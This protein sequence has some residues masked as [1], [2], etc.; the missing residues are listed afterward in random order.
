M[1]DFLARLRDELLAAENAR[2]RAQQVEAGASQTNGCRAELVMLGNG[3]PES[4]PR[5][6]W[7]AWVGNA[8]HERFAAQ[9]V[10]PGR[11]L[12]QRFSYR[13]VPCTIDRHD[14]DDESC[15]DWKSKGNAADIAV[16]RKD[17][18]K[19][20][21]IAQVHLGAAA[22]IEAGLP[23]RNVR[24]VYVPRDGDLSDAYV[25]EA[26]FD[27]SLADEAAEWHEKV[28]ALTFE[29][30]GLPVE[31]MVDGLRDEPPSFCWTYCSRVTACRGPRPDTLPLDEGV[32][33][34]AAEY[35]EAKSMQDEGEARAKKARKFLAAYGDLTSVGLQWTGGNPLTGDELDVDALRDLWEFVNG[36]LP[37][38]PKEG[39]SSRS[40]RRIK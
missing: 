19:P 22:L 4:D 13:G 8:M 18:P 25:W 20:R 37:T 7:S 5:L 40:L 30:S 31:E 29:R 17:G 6:G 32:A 24:L 9:L 1:S 34:V 39:T 33:D 3:V 2:D 26:P 23:V 11:T 10:G 28:R 21:H 27:R 12:E 16:I 35:L 38:K 15:T 36:D 14:A